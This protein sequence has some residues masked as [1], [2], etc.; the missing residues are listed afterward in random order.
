[1]CKC[2]YTTIEYY[3]KSFNNESINVAIV[4]H[5]ATSGKLYFKK[6]KNKKRIISFDDE[7][8]VEDFDFAM[9]NFE[10]FLNKPFAHNLF[11][12]K[13]DKCK[14]IHYLNSVNNAFLN[15]YRMSKISYIETE[16]PSEM[17]EEISKLVLYFDYEKENR[18]KKE[19]IDRI[20]RKTIKSML[21]D[22]RISFEEA[23]GIPEIGFGEP[24]K[25]DFKIGNTFIK[26]LDMKMDAYTN[27]INSAK[28]WAI[29]NDYF[30]DHNFKLIIA[31]NGKAETDQ[32]RAYLNIL[33]KY[34][35]NFCYLN[36][37]DSIICTL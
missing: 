21:N 20:I 27:R 7:L 37:L 29:N 17:F 3:P 14:D 22:K 15:E 33:K 19:E 11:N 30:E 9:R 4:L 16:T 36:D 2:A 32:E 8:N 26:V 28:V 13:I 35:V 12:T 24:I 34:N 10:R 18:P 6:A 1:M 25:V 5:D 31:L 23:Y